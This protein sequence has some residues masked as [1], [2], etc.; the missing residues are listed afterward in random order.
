MRSAASTG[1]ECP[2][3]TLVF[4]TRFL[5][6]PIST[7]RFVEADRP[8][9]FGPRKRGQSVCAADVRRHALAEKH[10]IHPI[11]IV[12]WVMVSFLHGIFIALNPPVPADE[13]NHE[14]AG[15]R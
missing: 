11:Q 8:E 10:S 12:L 6:G 15:E 1:E 14:H 4:Q 2:A 5:R 13:S 3:G 9:P 7:G